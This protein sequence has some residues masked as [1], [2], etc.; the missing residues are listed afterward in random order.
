MHTH[1]LHFGKKLCNWEDWPTKQPTS[2]DCKEKV[3]GGVVNLDK[4]STYLGRKRIWWS[5]DFSTTKLNARRQ[6]STLFK[7][8]QERKCELKI[9]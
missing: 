8:F 6:W 3:G 1:T 9:L 2:L 7:M 5:S 4:Y